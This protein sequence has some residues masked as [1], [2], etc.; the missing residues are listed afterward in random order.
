A[1]L[2]RKSAKFS[3]HTLID[4]VVRLPP[5]ELLILHLQLDWGARR[6]DL[7]EPLARVFGIFRWRRNARSVAGC[8]SIL[9][10]L[11]PIGPMRRTAVT[12]REFLDLEFVALARRQS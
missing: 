6:R 9:A 1:F 12:V 7:A 3:G 5:S 4:A 8:Q 10:F 2:G 11:Q